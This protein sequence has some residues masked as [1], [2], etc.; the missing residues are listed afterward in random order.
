MN[1][2]YNF[3]LIS[4]IIPV[5]NREKYILQGL[6][7]ILE[8]DYPNKEIVLIDDGSKDSTDAIIKNWIEEHKNQI[9][10]IYKSRENRGMVK[11]LNELIDRS[12]GKY[13]VFF[14]SDDYLKNNGISKRYEYL[15]THP[16]K[17]M[18]VA[19]CNLVDGDNNQTHESALIGIGK[20]NKKLLLTDAGMKK[21]M[22]LNGYIPGAVLMADK[23]VYE[24]MGKYDENLHVEDWVYYIRVVAKNLLGYV[25]EVVSAYRLHANNISYSKKVLL[26]AQDG[27][28]VALET[29]HEFKELKYKFFMLLRILFLLIYIP[30]IR[31]KFKLLDNNKVYGKNNQKFKLLIN[32]KIL[33]GCRSLKNA[34]NFIIYNNIFNKLNFNKDN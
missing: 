19:D 9:S 18:V 13:I 21:F 10:V 2:N 14:G 24:I 33:K 3:P 25:D 20:V 30:Y 8:E 16:E 17:L 11:T 7:S 23:K 15:R 6:N 31:F 29:F 22:I 4:V 12:N 5:Y 32:Q 26:N 34:F 1:N 28:K 27:L